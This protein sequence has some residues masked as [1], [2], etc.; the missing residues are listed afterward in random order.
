MADN[1]G[2]DLPHEPVNSVTSLDGD[3]YWS[4]LAASDL[5][6]VIHG[7][8]GSVVQAN[9]AFADLLGY[10]LEEAL[11]LDSKSVI[12]PD[13][14]PV[15]D[16]QAEEM[17][18]GLSAGGVVH[19]RLVRKD[20]SFIRARVRKSVVRDRG[21]PL[22]LTI[23]EEWGLIGALEHDVR[24][25]HLTGLLNRRGLRE[26][27]RVTYPYRQTFLAMADVDGLKKFN[28]R[29]GHAAGDEVLIAVGNALR[30]VPLPGA[31]AARWSGD[32]FVVCAPPGDGCSDPQA[33][34][35]LVRQRV[36]QP[37]TITGL[38][39]PI[40]PR[41]SVGVTVFDPMLEE[42]DVA[43]VRA[44]SAMYAHKREI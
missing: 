2:G 8:D 17:F 6:I 15:R 33:L 39:E 31:L 3:A 7:E 34:A 27:A 21:V 43:L 24:H 22:I 9:R 28:D 25:D 38:H 12:H 19:R 13:D 37:L 18:D 5:A 35:R 23:I 32:E 40:V 4:L 20:G 26:S 10:T 16:A 11:Q 1:R 36:G 14:L 42:L 41:I 44:D 30:D 29:Y